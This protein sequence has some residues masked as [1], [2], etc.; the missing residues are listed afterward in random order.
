MTT[1]VITMPILTSKDIA[2]KFKDNW[3][4]QNQQIH[5]MAPSIKQEPIMDDNLDDS[6]TSLNW[7]HNLKIMKIGQPTPPSSPTPVSMA[8]Q[9]PED[10]PSYVQ[11]QQLM[12]TNSNNRSGLQDIKPLMRTQSVPDT[13]DYKTNGAVKPPYSYATLIWMAMKDSKKSKI[14]LSAIYKWITDNF[15]YY[16][17]AEPSWQNSI[18]HN[19]SLNKC[20]QKV[21]RKKDEPGKGGFWRIDPVHAEMLENGILKKRRV[22]SLPDLLSSPPLKRIKIEP[23]DPPEFEDEVFE[24]IPK[25]IVVKSSSKSSSKKH[26]SKSKKSKSKHSKRSKRSRRSAILEDSSTSEDDN[27]PSSV[28]NGSF[29]WDSIFDSEIEVDGMKVKAE[30]ILDPNGGV[31]ILQVLDSPPHS[32]GNEDLSFLQDVPL[33][34]SIK[35]THIPKPLWFGEQTRTDD[36]DQSQSAVVVQRI[37]E[38]MEELFGITQLPPS[39]A[40]SLNDNTSHPWAESREQLEDFYFEEFLNSSG[41]GHFQGSTMLWDQ[42]MQQEPEK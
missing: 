11:K 14:T 1:K 35:G 26:K 38:S 20:F 8:N 40:S 22:N 29:Q 21:A 42:T 30:A 17:T 4:A 41:Y 27:L 39:P 12:L 24:T 31:Q 2:T 23:E 37:E 6:L 5:V 28:L 33:D 9:H 7:L 18:R 16:Q 19:L 32:E 34:L 3:L 15:K 13:I 10:L 36:L 25:P